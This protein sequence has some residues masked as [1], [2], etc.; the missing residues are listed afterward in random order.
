MLPQHPLVSAWMSLITL[1]FEST[2]MIFYQTLYRWILHILQILKILLQ[3]FKAV[4]GLAPLLHIPSYYFVY[5]IMTFT[6]F[7]CRNSNCRFWKTDIKVKTQN[8][9][10]F[11]ERWSFLDGLVE[12]QSA[13]WKSWDPASWMV[14]IVVLAFASVSA[15]VA[16]LV[17][18]WDAANIQIL[19]THLSIHSKNV[20]EGRLGAGWNQT[21][22]KQCS[23]RRVIDS[24]LQ[25]WVPR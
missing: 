24:R 15:Q 5:S 19:S 16:P 1:W 9:A 14:V 13:N 8:S 2:D 7:S 20:W 17:S 25:P 18:V 6:M 12:E 22:A 4:M 10:F 23:R 21:N 11:P 3:T